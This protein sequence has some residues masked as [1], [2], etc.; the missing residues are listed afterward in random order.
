MTKKVLLIGG[1]GFLGYYAT[2]E[3]LKL[4][5][6]VTIL[7]LPPLPAQGLFPPEVKIV[8]A[9][10][11]QLEDEEVNALL[12]GQD[13]LVYAA[14]ADDRLIPAKPAYLFFYKHNVAAT[15]RIISLARNAGIK[16]AVILG[17]Y[18]AH[19]ARIWP[20]LE[21][22]KH[23]PY[24]RSRVEQEEAAIATGGA[25]MAVMVLELPY[26]FGS[27]PGRVPIW[28]PLIQYIR[29]TPLI[30]YTNGGTNCVT[31]EQVGA[32]I[33]GAVEYGQA[34]QRYLIGGENLTW[35]ELLAK[36]SRL[37]GKEKPVITLPNGLVMI[38][39]FF[40][41]IVHSLRGKQSGLNP[42]QLV[43]LQTAMTFFDPVSAQQVLHFGSDDLDR[44]LQRTIEA[45]ED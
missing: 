27:M 34:G 9:D 7:A 30:F 35:K 43:K 4:G 39:T 38:G 32:A 37:L 45:C 16:R 31:V 19:F 36:I 26:I 18:F 40:L 2:Q 23:H 12:V 5:Y 17:S 13:A 22:T 21:L 42:V 44:A 41:E 3:L 14:G 1:T 8:L 29:K 20:E 25:E 6:E 33:A 15:L 11:N 28:K 24:I 10:L